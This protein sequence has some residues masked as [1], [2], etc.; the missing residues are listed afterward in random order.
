MQSRTD[1]VTEQTAVNRP[2]GSRPGRPARETPEEALADAC[3]QERRGGLAEAIERY[4]AAVNLAEDRMNHSVLSAG[5]RH[6]AV[7][8]HKCGDAR[9]A[10]DLCRRS[11]RAARRIPDALLAAE[12]LNT[13]GVVEMESGALD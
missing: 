1:E 6:L 13:L 5:L 12:A 3:A 10:R 2:L 9:R 11:Y 8:Y 4:E 7:V